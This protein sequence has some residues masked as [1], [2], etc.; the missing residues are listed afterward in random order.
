MSERA[1]NAE[2]A[3]TV[4]AMRERLMAK[5]I[6]ALEGTLR[7]LR[8]QASNGTLHPQVVIQNVDMALR[9]IAQPPSGSTPAAPGHGEGGS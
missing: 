4:R 1:L 3:E 8:T 5:R 2:D 6:A 7:Y 9:G